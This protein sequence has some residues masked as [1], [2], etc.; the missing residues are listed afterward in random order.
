MIKASYP[1]IHSAYLKLFNLIFSSQHVPENWCKSIIT[2]IHKAGNKMDPDNYRPICVTS[3]IAIL[4]CTLLND[5]LTSL[6]QTHNVINPAQIEFISKHRTSDHPFT[7]KTLINK[8]VYNNTKE[9]IFACFVHFRKAFDSVWHEGLFYKLENL[10]IHGNF[11]NIL[12]TIYCETVCAV[13]VGNQLTN[14][15]Q[16]S[17]GVRQGCPLS[18][19]LF[20]FFINDP[21]NPIESVNPAPLSLKDNVCCLLYA[22]DLLLLE[23]KAPASAFA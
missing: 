1:V 16:Y 5:R 9:K 8:H 2:P 20:K 10:N 19:N 21:I 4:F 7:P 12:K 11:L 13:E 6:F 23:S 18:P 3:C 17:K 14:F 22:D 15:F